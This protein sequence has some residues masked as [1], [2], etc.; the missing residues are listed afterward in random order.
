MMLDWDTIKSVLELGDGEA[1]LYVDVHPSYFSGIH[2]AV[3]INFKN[4]DIK[5][6]VRYPGFQEH[7]VSEYTIEHGD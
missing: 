6:T 2:N 1:K 4:V 5:I 3:D 7:E